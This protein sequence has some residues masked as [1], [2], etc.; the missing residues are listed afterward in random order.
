MGNSIIEPYF[1]DPSIRGAAREVR[2]SAALQRI[3]DAAAVRGVSIQ[4]EL[5]E[6]CIHVSELYR[7]KGHINSEAGGGLKTLRQVCRVADQFGKAVDIEYMA[8]EPK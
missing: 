5:D 6:E 2:L 8:D 4:L 3:V 1:P 7:D